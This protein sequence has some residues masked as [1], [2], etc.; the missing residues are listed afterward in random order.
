MSS[1][2]PPP[3]TPYPRGW[4]LAAFS[5]EIAASAVRPLQ[6]FGEDLVL[7][8]DSRGIP[9]LVD[10]YCPH[11]GAHLGHGGVVVDDRIRCP[12]HGWEFAGSTGACARIANG[13]PIPPK[14]RL[15]CWPLEEVDG[16]ILV[17][18]HERGEPPTWRYGGFP[19]RH[20]PGW[21]TWAHREWRLRARI[22]DITENDADVSHSPVMHGFTDDVPAIDVDLDGP[23]LQWRMRARVKLA[24]MGVPTLPA[25]GPL[26]HIPSRTPSRIN[27]TRWGISLGWIYNEVDLP[28]GLCFRTQ[29]VAT[30][31]PIDAHHCRLVLRHRIRTI[32]G[33]TGLV[34]RNYARL[35]N[36]TV[37]EDV[38]IWENK[39][40]RMRPAAS[41][42]D[43]AILRFR[44]W[45]RQFYDADE[46][47]AAMGRAPQ[48]GG[49]ATAIADA[50][51]GAE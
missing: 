1:R 20:Q 16:M 28:G 30:T 6:L 33:I 19:D 46:Y 51:A 17:W 34:L 45:A 22:Q 36:A 5:D 13:D 31:T 39:I 9:R 27:V 26:R 47:D 11:L 12:F 40:Y 32:P 49:E 23:R 42:S 35:F 24:A 48:G 15:R 10:A 3:L 41:R 7:F 14:A 4:Y 2:P 44:S 18:F 25:I 50:S 37:D 21:S 8:R 29:T 38:M 43:W